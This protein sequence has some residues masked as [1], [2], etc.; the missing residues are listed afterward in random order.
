MAE[1]EKTRWAEGEFVRQY[2]EKADIQ[3]PQ[4][5]RML[6]ILKSFYRHFLEGGGE[7]R[8]LDLGCG[9]G[10]LAHELLKLDPSIRAT[11]V[12]ASGQMLERARERL[13]GFGD[14]RFV[15]AAFGELGVSSFEPS[16]FRLV[17]SSLAI[18][19]LPMEEKKTLFRCIY[20]WLEAGGYF[21]NID[22]LLAPVQVLDD[23]YMELWREWIRERRPEGGYEEV[24]GYH[25]EEEHRRN[26]DTLEDQLAALKEAGFRD[27]D[28]FY[29]YGVFAV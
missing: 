18:H 10:F 9:D 26:L 24:I 16:E 12:D 13:A 20:S 25:R 3:I 28:C 17:V 1:F 5:R 4:R 22:V 7:T 15:K 29:K 2:L 6:D 21:V 19:H 8:L 14:V 23:W 27:V 11:L